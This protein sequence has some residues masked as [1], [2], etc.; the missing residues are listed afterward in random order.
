MRRFAGPVVT[1]I[2]GFVLGGWLVGRTP[3]AAAQAQAGRPKCVGVSAVWNPRGV[4]RVYRAFEDGTTE[5]IED[6]DQFKLSK[7]TKVGQ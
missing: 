7:W 6:A 1:L 2:V 3:P 4:Y 5:T